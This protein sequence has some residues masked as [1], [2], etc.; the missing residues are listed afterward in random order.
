MKTLYLI[1]HAKSSWKYTELDDF[2]RPLN[3][4][5]RRDAPEMGRFLKNNQVMPDLIMSSPAL[6]AATT[7]RV[8]AEIISYP[9]NGIQYLN[10]IYE[11][12]MLSIFD[13]VNCLDDKINSAFLV[14]HN[15]ALTSLANMLC[16]T[17][18]DNI[19]TCGIYCIELDIRIWNDVSEQCAK[20]KFFDYP[21]NISN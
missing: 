1:R 3:K 18:V 6:R 4:R 17:Y 8:L 20:L 16:N 12:S 5:G 13:T 15:P 9:L 2:E 21:K 14:G 19:P 7:A 10:Q 11:A